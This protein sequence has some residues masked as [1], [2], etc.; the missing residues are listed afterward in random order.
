VDTATGALSR[1]TG[2]KQ[3]NAITRTTKGPVTWNDGT[4]GR[5]DRAGTRLLDMLVWFDTQYGAATG[6]PN[7]YEKGAEYLIRVTEDE[8]LPVMWIILP[9]DDTATTLRLRGTGTERKTSSDG[10]AWVSAQYF[11][12]AHNNQSASAS[13]V[14][15][16][17]VNDS[18]GGF[19]NMRRGILQLEKNIT[20]Q[21]R[22]SWAQTV[23]ARLLQ[24]GR[25]T[26]LVMK[27][28]SALKGH[29]GLGTDGDTDTVIY[30]EEN[31]NKPAYIKIEGGEISGNTAVM[32][33]VRYAT[34]PGTTY[35][36]R[37]HQTGGVIKNNTDRLGNEETPKQVLFG[38][39][40]LQNDKKAQRPALVNAENGGPN[41]LPAQP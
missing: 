27:E 7:Q 6:S 20:I 34:L 24:I 30:A 17:K 33:I 2:I 26:T 35:Y 13:G 1:V 21:G 5:D 23:Y 41:F 14:N 38:T 19:F 37:F 9:E 18:N 28:G 16:P 36:G 12:T 29:T 40:S 10:S 31:A 25:Q 22:N 8:Q 32:A 4:G 39:N 15:Y 11:N 3:F